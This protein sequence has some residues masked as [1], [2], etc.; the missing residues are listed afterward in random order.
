MKII[1]LSIYENV[2]YSIIMS[3]REKTQIA[4]INSMDE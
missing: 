4:I 3:S 1:Y 2:F